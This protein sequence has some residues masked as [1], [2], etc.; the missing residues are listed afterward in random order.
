M[1]VTSVAAA[2]SFGLTGVA[3]YDWRVAVREML[4]RSDVNASGGLGVNGTS[5]SSIFDGNV[6]RP[7]CSLSPKR[8]T[9]PAAASEDNSEEVGAREDPTQERRIDSKTR[10]HQHRP[11]LVREW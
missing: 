7:W 2:R 4:K 10:H 5:I 9:I 11:H 3:R 8:A 6:S 1:V